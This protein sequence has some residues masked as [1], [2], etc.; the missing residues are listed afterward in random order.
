MD[1]YFPAPGCFSS[2]KLVWVSEVKRS[3]YFRESSLKL[4]IFEDIKGP[5]WKAYR[6]INVAD[7]IPTSAPLELLC[8]VKVW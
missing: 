3:I 5:I 1:H 6:H 2:D 8:T 4:R 7:Q